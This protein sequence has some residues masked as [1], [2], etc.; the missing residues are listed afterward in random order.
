MPNMALIFVHDFW[1][2]YR[3]AIAEYVTQDYL[4][5]TR[6]DNDDAI[7]IHHLAHVQERFDCQERT[8]VNSL[9]GFILH[10]PTQRL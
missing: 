1:N 2:E 7:G 6:I 8:F 3:A 10:H 4:I 5:T 9:D